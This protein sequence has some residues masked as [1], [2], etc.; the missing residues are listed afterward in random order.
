MAFERGHALV[1]GVGTHCFAPHINVPVTVRDA[2]AVADVLRDPKSCG[3]LN[4][5]VHVLTEAG[6]T[7][8]GILRELADLAA[9]AAVDDTVIVFFAGHGALGTDGEYY[10]LGHDVQLDGSRVKAGTG[11]NEG[12]LLD[13]LRKIKAKRMLLIFNACFRQYF[14]RQPRHRRGRTR[15]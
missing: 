2:E 7:R 8:T 6:A 5:R 13:A 3:Y 4:D 15:C 11:L 1:V 14:H 9:N 12:E 10:L